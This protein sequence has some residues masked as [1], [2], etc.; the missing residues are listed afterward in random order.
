M[1]AI[2]IM[3]KIVE[4]ER[5]VNTAARKVAMLKSMAERITSSLEQ[6]VVSHSRN[7]H[8]FEDSI[9]QL[10]E[11]KDEL[12]AV[13]KKYSLLF[14]FI[15][16]VMN[17]LENSDDED[18]LCGYFMEHMPLTEISVKLHHA[19]T[20]G[21]RRYYVALEN[22]DALLANIPVDQFPDIA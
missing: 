11:A 2:D 8:S 22:L 12:N 7:V 17:K 6:E 18:L 13:S 1:K 15:T 20:W 3:N 21:Y 9:L 5:D 19:K 10:S 14:N 16:D 4:L